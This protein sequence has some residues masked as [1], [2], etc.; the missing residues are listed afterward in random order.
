M[1]KGEKVVAACQTAI[2]T[3]SG[4]AIGWLLWLASCPV[5]A[6]WGGALPETL[7]HFTALNL[8]V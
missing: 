1:Y 7:C 3:A 8:V 4:V 2:A 6:A 5:L